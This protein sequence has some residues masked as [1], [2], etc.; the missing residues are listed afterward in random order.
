MPLRTFED[1]DAFFSYNAETG[2]LCWKVDRSFN[3][4]AGVELASVV[5]SEGY[6]HV[7][8]Q[9]RTY[10]QHRGAWL[11]VHK[12]WP[13]FEIDH[14]NHNRS[15]NRLVNL[16]VATR[17]ENSRNNAR[18][19]K[20]TT[21]VTGVCRHNQMGKWRAQIRV[22]GAQKHLG[23]FDTFEEAVAVRKTAELAG[24]Y[25]PNHGRA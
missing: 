25:H 12:S 13:E 14:I 23:L 5:N 7:K 21:G 4:K 8:L 17:I 19:K 15:D 3:I 10:K 22:D 20:N 2:K 11:L 24:G 16:R 18:S 9:G 6:L 1:A